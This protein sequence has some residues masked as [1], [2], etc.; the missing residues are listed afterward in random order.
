MTRLPLPARTER[1]MLRDFREEDRTLERSIHSDQSLFVHL[2]IEP[3]SEA[4]IDDYVQARLK[5]QML[6]EVGGTSAVVIETINGGDYVGAIQLTPL[7]LDPLQLGIGWL[8]LASQQGN[9]YV[10]E[11]VGK[12]IDLLFGSLDTHRIVADIM[13]GNDA[14][15]R[16][17]ERLGFRKEAHFVKSLN[18][19]DEWRDELVYSIL[20]DDWQANTTT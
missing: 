18:L 1:L 15:V 6:K 7:A 4:E 9:G 5:H 13:V 10:S 11:A 12:L 16:L 3:R 17:A 14:S 20:K 8:A 2:P 19:R